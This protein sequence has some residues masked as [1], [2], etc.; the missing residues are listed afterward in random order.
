MKLRLIKLV[1]M[2]GLVAAGTAALAQDI[3]ER[4]SSSAT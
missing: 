4:A 2:L 1:A 3:Q